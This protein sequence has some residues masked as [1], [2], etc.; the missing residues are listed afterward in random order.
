MV[1]SIHWTVK[2]L[3]GFPRDDGN[4]YEI[5]DGELHV[6]T[7]PSLTHQTICGNGSYALQSW[8]RQTGAGMVFLAP[9]VIF[10][11]DAAV[12]PDL[13]WV[14]RAR[15]PLLVGRDGKLHDAPDLVVEVLSPGRENERRDREIKLA[16]YGRRGVREYWLVDWRQREV[17]V[18]RHD[19]GALRLVGNLRE[20]DT[21]TFPHLPGFSSPVASLFSDLPIGQE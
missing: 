12:A 16:L 8:S 20:E 17:M 14:S 5:I 15:L 4:R 7:Q 18:Y 21:L 9:G 2:H 19:G 10:A 6:T 11:E 3:K 13:V 1:S